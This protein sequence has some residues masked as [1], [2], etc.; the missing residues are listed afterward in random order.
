MERLK[1]KFERIIKARPWDYVGTDYERYIWMDA[2]IY[3]RSP[4]S[5]DPDID[6]TCLEHQGR[7]CIYDEY[8]ACVKLQKDNPAI[9]KQQVDNLS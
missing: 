9:M 1:P 4:L 7:N 2:N 5:F 3:P 6:I 8:E